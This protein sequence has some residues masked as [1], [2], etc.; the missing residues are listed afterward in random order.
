MRAKIIQWRIAL[1]LIF[2][3]SAVD[4]VAASNLTN[5]TNI[6]DPNIILYYIANSWKSLERSMTDCNTLADPKTN[7]TS[8]LYL[9]V[10]LPMPDSVE[11]LQ[12]RCSLL[13]K[14]LPKKITK[15]GEINSDKI[16]PAGLLYLPYPYVVPGGMFNEMYG[17]DSYFIIRGLI[18]A[19]K[20][21][22]AYGIVEN[23][24]FE[25]EHYGGTLNGNRTYY[26]SRTQ[27]PFL[28]PIIRTVYEARGRNPENLKWLARAY[29]YAV[30]DYNLWTRSPHLASDTGLS[31][32]YDFG[33]G[34][35]SEIAQ[36]ESYYSDVIR[37]FLLHPKDAQSY[38]MMNTDETQPRSGFFYTITLCSK[39]LQKK[40]DAL[41]KRI[42]ACKLI[43]NVGLSSDFYKGDRAMRE[44]GFDVSF[45]FGPFSADTVNYAPVDLNSLLYKTEKDLEWMS[46]QLGRKKSAQKWANLA[47]QRREKINKYLWNEKQ[48]LYF[49]YN[50]KTKQQSNYPYA[51]TFY[52]L[53][54]GLASPSQAKKVVANLSSFEKSG[55]IVTSLR[56]TG[57]QWDYPYGWAPIQ[58]IAI[59]GL[60]QYDFR[61]DADRI[62]HKFLTMVLKNYMRD[63]TIREKYDVVSGSSQTDIQIGY[64]M[65]VIGFG[66]TNGVFLVLLKKLPDHVVKSK[67]GLNQNFISPVKLVNDIHAVPSV[68]AVTSVPSV[69]VAAA[70]TKEIE[71]LKEV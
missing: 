9:P 5:P 7:L 58:L 21:D 52:P 18:E 46:T 42:R 59:E 65:N 48:G 51:T 57:V 14:R 3:L 24:F 50:F 54:A 66:W 1:T 30:K 6:S 55:G 15:L 62:S 26:L 31:R 12:K 34:P 63:K 11:K 25:I 33:D 22:L 10:D 60:Y 35:V 44:S 70:A 17:W 56:E 40:Y 36:S 16:Q 45:R 28:A 2:S 67:L 23:F 61:D 49:D 29:N 71:K 41:K 64:K 68:P 8:V 13:V 43:K 32:Y 39:P 4:Y 47:T 37:Y 38:L 53:W 20:I 27:L 69:T 19:E